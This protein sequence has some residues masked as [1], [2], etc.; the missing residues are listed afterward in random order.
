MAND[1]V[2]RSDGGNGLGTATKR[3][4]RVY[5]KNGLSDGTDDLLPG[6]TEAND[7]SVGNGAAGNKRLLANTAAVSKPYI[8]YNDT[9]KKWELS[10]D[11]TTPIA[12]AGVQYIFR[13]DGHYRDATG[14]DITDI[15]I[16][17]SSVAAILRR[18]IAGAAGTSEVD[19]LKNGVSI[20]A[21]PA[22]RPKV[23]A[24]DGDAFRASFPTTATFSAGD[25]VEM[26][27]LSAETGNPQ[28]LVITLQV[29]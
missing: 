28:D 16:P 6:G 12:A 2:P 20:F 8:R 17:G 4:G 3:W 14:I 15:C 29:T 25:R 7:F 5:V 1:F 23:T 9:T 21:A 26:V 13:A 11:G 22:N 18:E 27:I 10:N 24:A 19:I